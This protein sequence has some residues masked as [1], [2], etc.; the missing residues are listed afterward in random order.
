MNFANYFLIHIYITKNIQIEKNDL[1]DD[2]RN[3]I[4][5]NLF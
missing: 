1:L 3:I 2:H 5:L 4:T